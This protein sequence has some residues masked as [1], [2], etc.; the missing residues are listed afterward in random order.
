[1]SCTAGD[2]NAYD[3]LKTIV[4]LTASSVPTEDKLDQMLRSISD[5]FQ[6]ERCLL[7][8]PDR[9]ASNGFLSRLA[10]EKEPLWVDEGSSFQRERV[11]P[12]EEDLLCPSFACLPLYVEASFK[13]I[14]YLGFSK[15]R[16]FSPGEADLLS[17]VAQEMGGA[18]RNADLHLM[19]EEAISGLTVLHELGKAVTSTLKLDDLFEVIVTTGLKILRATGGVLRIEDQKTRELK[20]RSSVGV[21]HQNRLDEKISRR[22]FF[23]R[24]PFF[25]NHFSHHKGFLSFLCVPLLSKGRVFGTL[26]FYDKKSTPARFDE[27]DLQLLMTM[28]NQVSCSLENAL[29]QHEA[30]KVAQELEKRV[31]QLSTLW[32]LNKALLTTVNFERILQMTLTAITLG[33]GLGFNRAML[34]L[35]N[36]KEHVLEGKMAVG[37]DSPEDAGRIWSALSQRKGSPSDLVTQL[38]LSPQDNSALDSIVKGIQIPLDRE[39]CVLSKTVLEG[40]PFNM[41]LPQSEEG[42]LQ[43]RCERGCH[44]GSEVGCYVGEHLSRDPSVYSFATVPLWGKG[45]VIGV[46]LVDNLYNRNPI[47]EEDIHFLGMF[48][49]QA[50]LA[51][52][53]A[54]LYRNLEEVHQELKETQ[55]LLVHQEKMVALG[56]LSA[57]I[58]HEIKNPLVSIGGFAR[59]LDRAVPDESS[60]KRYAQTIMKEVIRLEGI[61]DHIHS[62]TQDE[63]VAYREHDLRDILEDGL[64]MASEGFEAAGIRLVKEYAEEVPEVSGDYQQLRQAFFNLISNAYQ[65]MKEKGTLFLRVYPF[66][67]NGSAHVRIEVEDTGQG[68]DPENLHNIFNPFYTTRKSSLGLGLPTVHK[69]VTSHQGQIEV[70]NCIGKGVNFI[71]TLP[72]IKGEMERP[73]GLSGKVSG[74]A[75]EA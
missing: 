17:A 4:H 69:I 11:L 35:V 72:A 22:V 2:P 55:A 6:A 73:N 52:E 9:I 7:L 13:G 45:K 74:K 66:S 8:R 50:G 43:T 14:L 70:N 42:W 30:S 71:I 48:S 3:L 23:T 33:E 5:A 64:S 24:T 25:L 36:D 10:S 46:L 37:P 57:T 75:F 60:E 29:S 1:M 38:Q 61:L 32:E 27:R 54:L 67:K 51:I 28:A 39:Q 62:Y 15:S 59:R 44:L 18:V 12:E 20:L 56:E 53:N 21:Y 40:R 49:T 34:F 26:A 68:I 16:K 31:K 19:A 58:A 63:S 65:T 47:K 41:Q